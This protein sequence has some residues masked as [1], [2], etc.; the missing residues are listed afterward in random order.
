[1]PRA[2]RS[3]PVKSGTTIYNLF[4]EPQW[5]VACKRAGW[6]QWQVFLGFNMVF[7]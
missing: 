3:Q 6:P 4:V 5:S 7:K 2:G 1:V